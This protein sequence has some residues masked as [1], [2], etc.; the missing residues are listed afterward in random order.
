VVTLIAVGVARVVGFF[1]GLFPISVLALQFGASPLPLV[2]SQVRGVETYGR[3]FAVTL[4]TASGIRTEVS[5]DRLAQALPGPFTRVK[6]YVDQLAFA[7]LSREPRRQSFLR[8]AACAGGPVARV[9]GVADPV[10]VRLRLWS[11]VP[12]E[13][14]VATFDV[15]CG[16]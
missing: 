8:Q 9:L 15:E 10:A 14:A 7:D 12:R 5:G 4:T 1:T 6:L 13:S 2:F 11:A 16:S 3:R